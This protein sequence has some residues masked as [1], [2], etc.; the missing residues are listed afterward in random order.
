MKL[1]DDTFTEDLRNGNW[2]KCPKCGE[3]YIGVSAISRD[4]NKT[5]IC[6]SCGR[7][8]ALNA[9]L[10]ADGKN[11]RFD[12]HGNIVDVKPNAKVERH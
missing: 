1:F 4:D 2:K 7:Y 12:F 11:Y 6:S 9:K 5:K 3:T 10:E 8:E